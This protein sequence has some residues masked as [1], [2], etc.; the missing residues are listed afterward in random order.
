MKISSNKFEI[1]DKHR[2]MLECLSEKIHVRVQEN[3]LIGFIDDSCF[4]PGEYP[5]KYSVKVV[6]NNRLKVNEGSYYSIVVTDIFMPSPW[7]AIVS[8]TL[9][10]QDGFVVEN[11]E[12]SIKRYVSFNNDNTVRIEDR[13]YWRETVKY[14][15]PLRNKE[16][17][18]TPITQDNT[19]PE[20]WSK[21]QQFLAKCERQRNVVWTYTLE[22][23]LMNDAYAVRPVTE[24]EVT[25]EK[26]DIIDYFE[27]DELEKVKIFKCVKGVEILCNYEDGKLLLKQRKALWDK[28]LVTVPVTEGTLTVLSRTQGDIICALEKHTVTPSSFDRRWGRSESV[29]KTFDIKKKNV[30]ERLRFECAY[31]TF[32]FVYSRYVYLSKELFVR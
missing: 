7:V 3:G 5:Y 11:R 14:D 6:L 4:R 23:Y 8:G 31:G 25:Y 27:G 32:E 24:P 29:Q 15:S 17:N 1:T 10:N 21:Y 30:F 18:C 16:V 2:K 12:L 20:Q 19:T 28:T 22:K 26:V 9:V 13:S